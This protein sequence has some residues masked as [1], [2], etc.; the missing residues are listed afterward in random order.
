MVPCR[1]ALA[2]AWA[3]ALP[4][5]RLRSTTPTNSKYVSLFIFFYSPLKQ[6]SCSDSLI[7]LRSADAPIALY[8]TSTELENAGPR[9]RV[10][11]NHEKRPTEFSERLSGSTLVV[12]ATEDD[13]GEL[14]IDRTQLPEIEPRSI[15]ELWQSMRNLSA[16]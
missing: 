16:I 11:Q 5:L 10:V 4:P 14:P 1:A 13:A 9:G 12:S 7:P 8:S 15:N 6:L 2:V 3:N